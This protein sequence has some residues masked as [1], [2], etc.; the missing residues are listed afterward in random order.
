MPDGW[1]E[2]LDHLKGKHHNKRKQQHAQGGGVGA[3]DET[4]TSVPV[5][6]KPESDKGYVA[7]KPP[8]SMVAVGA[9]YA[10][11][12]VAV[13]YLFQYIAMVD[14]NQINR[15]SLQSVQRAFMTFRKVDGVR[16]ANKTQ[17]ELVGVWRFSGVA[18]NSGTTPATNVVTHFDMDS[19]FDPPEG[20]FIGTGGDFVDSAGP[21]NEFE[22][23]YLNRDDAFLGIDPQ[24]PPKFG[25]IQRP[26]TFWGWIVYRDVF[27]PHTTWH[28]TEFCTQMQGVSIQPPSNPKEGESYNMTFRSCRHHN[29]TDKDCS[30]Y[31][32]V[33]DIAKKAN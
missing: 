17:P 7:Y 27:F 4:P 18:E 21:K 9:L 25:A 20:A 24:H 33:V 16:R 11:I 13:I 6:H 1:Q 5:H 8:D 23:G 26:I 3:S 14:S 2:R 10:G 15:E 19:V 30:D 31:Q 28:L 29:C 12:A 22:F 32:Q